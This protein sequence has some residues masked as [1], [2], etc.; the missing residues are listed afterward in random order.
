VYAAGDVTIGPVKQIGTAVG[1]A[2]IAASEAFGYYQKTLLLQGLI[3]C[4][5]EELRERLK[6]QVKK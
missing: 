6:F 5:L 4:V 1:E 3:P 2:I